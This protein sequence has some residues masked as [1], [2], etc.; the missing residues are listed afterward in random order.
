MLKQEATSLQKIGWST[1]GDRHYLATAPAFER[2]RATWIA[3]FQSLEDGDG[4]AMAAALR[5]LDEVMKN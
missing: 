1:S 4:K 3:L 2:G 5:Q